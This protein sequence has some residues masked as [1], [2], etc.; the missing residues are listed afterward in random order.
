MGRKYSLLFFL[1]FF[2]NFYPINT[3]EKFILYKGK[4]LNIS[5][6]VEVFEDISRNI[7]EIDILRGQYDDRFILNKNNI[8]YLRNN[9][10][11]YIKLDIKNLSH[12]SKLEIYSRIGQ[13]T[14]DRT[15]ISH[16]YLDKN[17]IIKNKFLRKIE[18]DDK[19]S[20][21]NYSY[22]SFEILPDET[23]TLYIKLK[24]KIISPLILTEKENIIKEERIYF[25]L[26][27]LFFGIS[28]VLLIVILML[29]LKLK[30]IYFI[31]YILIVIFTY[32]KSYLFIGFLRNY[33]SNEIAFKIYAILAMLYT[34]S[35]VKFV[36]D[37]LRLDKCI[38]KTK[39]KSYLIITEYI[40]VFINSMYLFDITSLLYYSQS[41]RHIYIILFT[42]ILYGAIKRYNEGWIY[43]AF[44]FSWLP[45]WV[46]Y[47]S[48]NIVFALEISSLVALFSDIRI[49]EF[50]EI[51]ANLILIAVILIYNAKELWKDRNTVE[52]QEE[53]ARIINGADNLMH[54][55]L[56]L[57]HLYKKN[58]NFSKIMFFKRKTDRENENI[59]HYDFSS[60][61]T[62]N[63]RQEEKKYFDLAKHLSKDIFDDY[64]ICEDIQSNELYKIFLPEY[65]SLISLRLKFVESS[66]LG[67]ILILNKNKVEYEYNE[68]MRNFR[69]K[70]SL[71]VQYFRTLDDMREKYGSIIVEQTLRNFHIE[72]LKDAEKDITD[73]LEQI[74]KIKTISDKHITD[75][76]VNVKRVLS[77][78]YDN[79]EKL[80]LSLSKDLRYDSP[81]KKTKN[82]MLFT[83]SVVEEMLNYI[84]DVTRKNS[85]KVDVKIVTE[86]YNSYE[87]Y[88]HVN[89]IK[90]IINHLLSYIHNR[91]VKNS[92]ENINI[93]ISTGLKE[94]RLE[95][96][97]R[98]EGA[99]IVEEELRKE[100]NNEVHKALMNSIRS[101]LELRRE[102]NTIHITYLLNVLTKDEKK[103]FDI[104]H[105]DYDDEAIDIQI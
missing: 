38:E 20:L 74:D 81:G 27:N 25:L 89:V 98:I 7:N 49:I 29:Y 44:F 95:I 8:L 48:L 66:D 11:Y 93:M 30:R 41:I 24:G 76:D 39:I 100:Y 10:I 92:K 15:D 45:Q 52:D 83:Y 67:Y 51:F 59:L 85:N 82:K 40:V 65:K 9:S 88:G 3:L 87:L 103:K 90:S 31:Y 84:S 57:I 58:I 46:L 69:Y 62:L 28:F 47:V 68:I 101:K 86:L 16:I 2:K 32:L 97:T 60:P 19:N 56:I 26:T 21:I 14:L 33:M 70:S 102:D 54:G 18:K 43:K 91:I 77:L 50:L 23:K 5:K 55:L 72:V 94:G 78:F 80:M 64:Y 53:F 22:V 1:I 17:N 34:H 37:I 99:E 63:E 35:L 61:L 104:K 36:I 12:K 6:K 73:T 71:L 79:L 13:S 105:L 75:S 96:D 42:T 4:N